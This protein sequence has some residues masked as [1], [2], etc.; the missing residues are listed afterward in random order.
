V[1]IIYNALQKAQRNRHKETK[2]K[3]PLI[4][5]LDRILIG[6]TIALIAVATHDYMPDLM[7]HAKHAANAK[8][9]TTQAPMADASTL[10]VTKAPVAVA[11]ISPGDPKPVFSVNLAN[12]KSSHVL[13]GVYLSDDEKIALINNKFFHLG[14]VVDGMKLVSIEAN[15]IVLRYADNALIL[16]TEQS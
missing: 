10:A 5:W 2:K 11:E 16:Q 9:A 12:Y 6:I 15:R 8:H 13:S 14:D 4:P 1:S 3:V 7:E